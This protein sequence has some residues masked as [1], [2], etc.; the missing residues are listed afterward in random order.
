MMIYYGEKAEELLEKSLDDYN[1]KRCKGYYKEQ[2]TFI[3][4]DN[5]SGQCN[6]EEFK[7][8]GL[9]ICWLENY[10]EISEIDDFDVKKIRDGLFFISNM[11]QL[12][13]ELTGEFISTSFLAIN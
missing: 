3:A 4:F 12:K 10:F 7:S 2:N 11:G 1:F 6:V 8:E 13:A 5:S 9:A